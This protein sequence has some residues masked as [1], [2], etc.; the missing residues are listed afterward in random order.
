MIARQA[1]LPPL[2][3]FV[4]R[5]IGSPSVPGNFWNITYTHDHLLFVVVST[6]FGFILRI[7]EKGINLILMIPFEIIFKRFNEFGSLEGAK[8]RM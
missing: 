8:C 7:S 3:T 5:K 4:Y 1:E 6:I 2:N